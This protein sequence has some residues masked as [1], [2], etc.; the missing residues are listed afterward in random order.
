VRT[1][2]ETVRKLSRLGFSL[3]STQFRSSKQDAETVRQQRSRIV[4]VLNVPR[5]YASD[6]H[7][8]RPCWTNFLSILREYSP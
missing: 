4:Q 5:G 7:S 2:S 8:L 3:L 6:L 1:K